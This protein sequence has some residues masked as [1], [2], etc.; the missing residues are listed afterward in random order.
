MTTPIQLPN[1]NGQPLEMA[2]THTS[3]GRYNI[4]EGN[5]RA[6]IQNIH[7]AA[8]FMEDAINED[9]DNSALYVEAGNINL[10]AAKMFNISQHNRE[11]TPMSD[12]LTQA[13][14]KFNDAL[15]LNPPDQ[16]NILMQYAET[17]LTRAMA[18]S[19][20][21]LLEEAAHVYNRAK[22]IAKGTIIMD[23]TEGDAYNLLPKIIMNL[24]LTYNRMA[25]S[26]EKKNN[27]EQALEMH[28]KAVKCAE[29]A[30]RMEP[31]HPWLQDRKA[32][33]LTCAAAAH[34]Q[35]PQNLD[36]AEKLINKAY[37]LYPKDPEVNYQIGLLALKLERSHEA[38]LRLNAALETNPRHAPALEALG[39]YYNRNKD[40]N[41]A[42]L[43]YQHALNVHPN[44][45][46]V[47]AKLSN[48]KIL[49]GDIKN[50]EATARQAIEINPLNA[51]AH[52]CLARTLIAGEE[53]DEAERYIDIA[54]RLEPKSPAG[55]VIKARLLSVKDTDG[56]QEIE[57]YEKALAL[58]PKNS[59]IAAAIA[60]CHI[61]RGQFPKAKAVLNKA[62]DMQTEMNIETL[63]TYALT[64]EKPQT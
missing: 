50:G 58:S 4:R 31:S 53:Y 1:Q 22:E 57:A 37:N 30:N 9:P 46:H 25:K 2:R 43:F 44:N 14:T 59:T 39:D 32:F 27:D 52:R 16:I 34:A 64:N 54:V 23:P 3:W 51:E 10:E 38:V 55:H 15:A 13:A 48:I 21:K 19:S 49:K 62:L 6:A 20:H 35:V 11:R 12:F 47:M 45:S 5:A 33:I 60:R 29:D 61:R 56:A 40:F 41:E 63:L 26:H 28:D 42:Q 8:A 36:T 17:I 24:A 7:R 18:T